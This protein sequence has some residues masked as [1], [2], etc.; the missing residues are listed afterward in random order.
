V[1]KNTNNRPKGSFS[2]RPGQWMGLALRG[3]QKKITARKER[4][5]DKKIAGEAKRA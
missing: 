3:P 1:K 5:L 4:A 2:A